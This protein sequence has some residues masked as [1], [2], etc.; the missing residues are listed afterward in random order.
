MREEDESR[1]KTTPFSH[2]NFRL[3][4][5][6]R[7]VR[8]KVGCT[9]DVVGL[10]EK[11]REA[12]KETLLM[13]PKT[14]GSFGRES[15][16][17]WEEREEE[18][19]VVL[20]MP[21]AYGMK[22]FGR[23]DED[24][25]CIGKEMGGD[26][27]F[28]GALRDQQEVAVESV[29]S[30]L[31]TRQ[32]AIL[33]A[34]CGRGKTVMS[35]AALIRL[36]SRIG[37]SPPRRVLVMVHKSFLVDQWI[38]RLTTFLPG[39][40]LGR[41]QQ[42]TADLDA[43]VAIGMIQSLATHKYEE[44]VYHNFGLVVV[45]ECHHMS[46]PVFAR[47]LRRFPSKYVLGLSAT[48]K[49]ADGLECLLYMTMGSICYEWS[50]ESEPTAV[51]VVTY[52]GK[53]CREAKR[54]DG[55]VL[56]PLMINQIVKDGQRNKLI[57]DLIT[58][59][60]SEGRRVILLSERVGHLEDLH[61][62]LS[63]RV[64]PSSLSYYYG[65]RKEDTSSAKVVLCTYQMASEGLDLPWLDTCFLSTP[66]ANVIQAVGRVQ[67]RHPDKKTPLVLDLVDPYS[68]FQ[69]WSQSRMRWYRSESFSGVDPLPSKKRGGGSLLSLL[70]AKRVE[71]EKE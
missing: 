42:N 22:Q 69:N 33:V 25:R 36:W 59:F 29:L 35:I 54:A 19:E 18:G 3:G 51:R 31:E 10:S 34:G 52:E 5:E 30:A 8:T 23:A 32:N 38:E 61:S 64:D 12:H 28:S 68:V 65:K 44:D 20:S 16:P 17:V 11:E 63:D 24:E 67:R 45:D 4:R 50:S 47:S 40:K 46:A 2:N 39:A 43:D 37:L 57:V 71:E 21:R 66:R 7:S 6:G 13:K 58:D 56:T 49:R 62:R 15:F 27:S 41:I 26:F 70:P 60:V 1:Q 14:F 53:Q 9:Y 55:T 48:P